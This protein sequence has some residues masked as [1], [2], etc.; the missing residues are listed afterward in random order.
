MAS[1]LVNIIPF[2]IGMR[3]WW[4][5]GAITIFFGISK[6]WVPEDNRYMSKSKIVNGWLVTDGFSYQVIA[7]E[8]K[9]FINTYAY[10]GI[11]KF[12]SSKS[13][14]FYSLLSHRK[15][16]SFVLRRKKKRVFVLEHCEI[17][18]TPD[19]SGCK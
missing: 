14:F 11:S 6:L 17:S 3:P 4:S 16:W 12:S 1:S 15:L 18:D 5:K 8:P 10:L 9:G 19:R 2:F 13:Q 7:P